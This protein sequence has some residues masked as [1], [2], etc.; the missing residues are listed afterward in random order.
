M[1]I[2]IPYRPSYCD[3]KIAQGFL[4]DILF[5]FYVIL[6]LLIESP[7]LFSSPAFLAAWQLLF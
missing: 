6:F 4:W 1:L 7:A 5:T 2:G 3:W